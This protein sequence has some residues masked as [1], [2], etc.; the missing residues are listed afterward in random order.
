MLNDI[1]SLKVYLLRMINIILGGL[2]YALGFSLFI[3][4][5]NFLGGGI[6]GI[7]LILNTLFGINTSIAIIIINI[8]IFIL[9]YKAIDKHFIISSFVG[10]ISFSFSIHITAPLAGAL[11]VPHEIL[12]AIYGGV[13]TGIGMGL[14]FKSRASFG[15]TDVI[16]AMIKKNHSINLGT[17][18]FIFNLIIVSCA[19][20]IFEPY[21][22]MYSLIAMFISSGVID[23]VI[24][25]FEKRISVMIVSTEHEKIVEYLHSQRRGATLLHA[26]GSYYREP[27]PVIYTVIPSTRLAKLKDFIHMVD[28]NAF[29]SVT[30]TTEIMGHW[31]QRRNRF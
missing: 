29:V 11:Y 16:S 5:N 13:F 30:N 26:E 25:G 22:G 12:G 21:K 10:M 19:S 14:V 24:A 2:I 7:A 20:I 4:P 15:G 9:G 18:L 27:V 28:I 3:I 31:N 17:T 8:P 6:G 1:P 23:K